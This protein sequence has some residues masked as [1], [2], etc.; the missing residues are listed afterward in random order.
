MQAATRRNFIELSRP[1]AVL[2]AGGR[3]GCTSVVEAERSRIAQRGF[4]D[5]RADRDV[6]ARLREGSVPVA[7]AMR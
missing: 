3:D 7:R 4:A 2:G 1:G 6:A 5:P